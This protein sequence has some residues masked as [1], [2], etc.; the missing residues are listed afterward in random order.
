[1]KV[2]FLIDAA[3]IRDNKHIILTMTHEIIFCTN[4]PKI[5]ILQN[6]TQNFCSQ[7]K[8]ILIYSYASTH[9]FILPILFSEYCAKTQ[10]TFSVDFLVS[11]L[12]N[13]CFPC[14]SH[15]YPLFSISS[16]F[17]RS[18]SCHL[19]FSSFYKK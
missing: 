1:M 9:M 3:I 2:K 13:A 14:E 6:S 7:S 11:L 4:D 16:S 15:P 10:H 5:H 12:R 18:T 8:R 17:P 19:P